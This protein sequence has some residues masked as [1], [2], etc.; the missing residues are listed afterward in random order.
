[1]GVLRAAAGFVARNHLALLAGSCAA[2]LRCNPPALGRR[3]FRRPCAASR[4]SRQH[5]SIRIFAPIPT[6]RHRFIVS[7]LQ[8]LGKYYVSR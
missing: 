3:Q 1:M 6:T 7:V 5:G 2:T 8:L 4:S